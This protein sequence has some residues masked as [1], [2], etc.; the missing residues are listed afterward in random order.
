MRTGLVSLMTARSIPDGRVATHFLCRK[1]EKILPPR[2]FGNP[3]LFVSGGTVPRIGAC[4]ARRL[5]FLLL[6]FLL[7][8]LSSRLPV[9]ST[10]LRGRA[11]TPSG[12][13]ASRTSRRNAFVC[14]AAV[15]GHRPE[16]DEWVTN[17][18]VYAHFQQRL[19]C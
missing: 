11:R 16:E 8:F 15:G 13:R 18:S 10:A 17:W 3:S 6:S 9:A 4:F 12:E 14:S 5:F 19:Y 1:R 7:P 2:R